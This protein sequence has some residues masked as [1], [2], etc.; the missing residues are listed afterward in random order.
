MRHTKEQVI[1]WMERLGEPPRGKAAAMK[2]PDEIV[3]HGREMDGRFWLRREYYAPESY[4]DD[5][6]S[7]T[8]F[9]LSHRPGST[10]R[11][12]EIHD[13]S[14]DALKERLAELG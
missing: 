11:V 8:G 5:D 14:R 10:R 6:L 12:V 1:E 3:G 13:E 9:R 4:S 7:H 2:L